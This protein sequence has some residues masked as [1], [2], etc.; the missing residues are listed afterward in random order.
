MHKIS[1]WHKSVII[2]A[3]TPDGKI[4]MHKKPS[5]KTHSADKRAFFGGH[6][7]SGESYPDAAIRELSEEL[8]LPLT[9]LSLIDLIQIGAEGKFSDKL[10]YGTRKNYEWS[11]LYAYFLPPNF[12]KQQ[13][14]E[15]NDQGENIPVE[16]LELSFEELFHQYKKNPADFADDVKRI[17]DETEYWVLLILDDRNL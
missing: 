12:N 1:Y 7:K 2:I 3:L 16:V 8:A 11:T 10:D 15:Q 6:V 4:L 13:I 9:S 5:F 14:T 17:F